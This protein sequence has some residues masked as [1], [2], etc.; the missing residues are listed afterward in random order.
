MVT[1]SDEQSHEVAVAH[2]VNGLHN[3]L[4][5]AEAGWKLLGWDCCHPVHPLTAVLI[6][7]VVVHSAIL[8]AEVGTEYRR[9]KVQSCVE[10]QEQVH[11]GCRGSKCSHV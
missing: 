9:S 6:E 1:V 5:E 2:C 11:T 7:E 4:I 10:V 3:D 8:Q